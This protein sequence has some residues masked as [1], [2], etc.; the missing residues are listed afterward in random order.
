MIHDRLAE[1]FC[2]DFLKYSFLA[3]MVKF[4][5]SMVPHFPFPSIPPTYFSSISLKKKKK[6]H[7]TNGEFFLLA[8][9]FCLTA[10]AQIL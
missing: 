6:T 1:I 7:K 4:I 5:F 2:I 10:K 8:R 9:F 3:W